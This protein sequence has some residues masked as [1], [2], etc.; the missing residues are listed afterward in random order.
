MSTFQFIHYYKS[1]KTNSHCG[2][3][4]FHLYDKYLVCFHHISSLLIN[5]P[6]KEKAIESWSVDPRSLHESSIWKPAFHLS[7]FIL[8]S[9]LIAKHWVTLEDSWT[10]RN[11]FHFQLPETKPLKLLSYYHWVKHIQT[12]PISLRGIVTGTIF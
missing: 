5:P 10:Q 7:H 4:I 12:L 9:P 6:W 1:T 8:K 2:L 11:I 3:R